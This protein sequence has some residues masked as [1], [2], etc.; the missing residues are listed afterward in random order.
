[1]ITR[2]CLAAL[3]DTAGYFFDGR[4]FCY[5]EDTDLVL[6]ANLLGYRPVF[7][8]EVLALHEGQASS[9]KGFNSFIAHHGL[10]NST[11]LVI[12]LIPA[13]QL[14]RYGPLH[15]LAHLMTVGNHLVH[16]RITLIRDTY[17]DVLKQFSIIAADRKVIAAST[18]NSAKDWESL[19]ARRFYREGYLSEALRE[20]ARRFKRSFASSSERTDS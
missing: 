5:C 8:N 1:M 11:W 18:R 10:R 15:V 14:L 12:K 6:R 20:I 7:V 19:I 16:G 4:F 13:R 2:D 3:K 9:G 17:S